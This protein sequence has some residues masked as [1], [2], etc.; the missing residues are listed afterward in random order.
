MVTLEED[1]KRMREAFDA[2]SVER[3]ISRPALCPLFSTTG[4]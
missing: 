1:V 3:K 4:E 2:I